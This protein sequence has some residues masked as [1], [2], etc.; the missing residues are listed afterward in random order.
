MSNCDKIVNVELGAV[1]WDHDRW[2]G[3]FYPH[4]L[5]REWRLTCYA[6][7]YRTVLIPEIYWLGG[8]IPEYRQWYEDVPDDFRFYLFL[9]CALT[10]SSRWSNI[11]HSVQSLKEKLGGLL[12]DRHSCTNDPVIARIGA[13]CPD[14][15]LFGLS[16][17]VE[18]GALRCWH[19]FSAQ[20]LSDIGVAQ[21]DNQPELRPLRNLIEHFVKVSAGNERFLF[22]D[23]EFS[24]LRNAT[25]IARLL[26]V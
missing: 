16:E 11:V 13:S 2:C 20:G 21:F 19:G 18:P 6:N 4:D 14:A 3:G 22:I 26:G 5:P 8:N 17:L 25:T 12:V 15:K 23:G 10:A 7:E 24:I 1:G 9:S